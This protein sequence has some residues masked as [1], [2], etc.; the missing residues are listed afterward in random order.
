[1][2]ERD[3]VP[4][5]EEGHALGDD[6]HV[7]M[8]DEDAQYVMSPRPTRYLYAPMSYEQAMT[9]QRPMWHP[10]Y[11]YAFA[12]EHWHIVDS[13]RPPERFYSPYHVWVQ[14]CGSC[15]HKTA[16]TRRF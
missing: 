12:K 5:L 2:P 14:R 10:L 4:L 6:E 7:S 15:G 3:A 8:L 11:W 1:M 9:P 13:L 16:C